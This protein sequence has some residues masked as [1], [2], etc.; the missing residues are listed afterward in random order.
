MKRVFFFICLALTSIGSSI[1]QIRLKGLVVDNEGKPV[2]YA[3]VGIKGT[4][5]ATISN[6][7]G[8]FSLNVNSLPQVLIISII[9]YELN[10]TTA[11]SELV[12]IV[13]Q[14]KLYNFKDMVVKADGAYQIFNKAYRRLIQHSYAAF[15]GK[16]FYRLITKN[17]HKPTELME[18]FYDVQ[19]TPTGFNYWKLRH[20]R[21]ATLK[22][23]YEK[24]FVVSIDFSALAKFIDLTNDPDGG[25][26]FPAFPFVSDAKQRYQF[27][28]AGYISSNGK[29]LS[30]VA[31]TPRNKSA[32]Y[33]AG[34]AFID[35]ISGNLF[36]LELSY[37]KPIS[38][39]IRSQSDNSSAHDLEIH[40]QIQFEEN[41]MKQMLFSWM[42]IDLKYRYS[43]FAA[44]DFITS[45]I[46]C[47]VYEKSA[48]IKKPP[49]KT[50]TYQFYSD[51]EAIRARLY[52]KPF[53]DDNPIIQQTE[54]EKSITQYFDENGYFGKGYNQT[55]DTLL[56]PYKGYIVL[57]RKATSILT[58]LKESPKP[59]P[60]V[61]SVIQLNLNGRPQAAIFASLLAPFN[62]YKDSFYVNA[63]PLLDTVKSWISDTLKMD[64]SFY[65]IFE[66]YSRN[67]VVK[68]KKLLR[69]IRKLQDAC[70]KEEQILQMIKSAN[71]AFYDES[72]ELFNETWTDGKFKIW[73][74]YIS[75]EE[76]EY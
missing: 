40:Y 52:V 20:G 1:A 11:N 29:S 27:T 8:Q 48:P 69:D 38:N 35:E 74:K 67:A 60:E 64:D 15:D 34:K 54:L 70:G 22:D 63:F 46:K 47:F 73:E 31:F 68:A 72:V 75:L 4:T 59:Y 71:E 14:P 30:I 49:V 21:Y 19:A 16:L 42:N 37:A 58:Q 43:H 9:G 7:A 61:S 26:K 3:T 25:V 44:D 5:K 23:S 33:F 56:P 28:N 45:N 53:W 13:M 2:S 50:E 62:C 57:G 41:N 12:T 55:N 18:G 76:K 39:L 66:L 24:D 10:E 36:R 32:D 65:Y 6:E 51:Y 17:K